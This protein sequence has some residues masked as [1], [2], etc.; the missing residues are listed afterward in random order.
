M[1]SNISRTSRARSSPPGSR[2]PVVSLPAPLMAPPL[3]QLVSLEAHRIQDLPDHEVNKILH[4]LRVIVES[5]SG[6]GYYAAGLGNCCHVL[7]M[8]EA[9]R[10]LALQNHEPPSLLQSH[11]RHPMNEVGPGTVGDIAQSRDARGSYDRRI[12]YARPARWRREEV[13]RGIALHAVGLDELFS[14]QAAHLV[15]E[16]LLTHLGGADL[17][18]HI[19]LH[20]GFYKAYRIG[21]T[22]CPGN[23]DE[24]TLYGH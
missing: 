12:R 20:E 13:V 21:G 4:R 10:H 16:D 9:V 19:V 18:E 6:G 2:L 11:V 3:D 22:A 1:R 17:D 24:S 15:G 5:R 8:H 7:Y 23:A 14:V